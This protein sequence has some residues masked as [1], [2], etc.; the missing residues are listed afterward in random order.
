MPLPD[1]R[2]GDLL[3]PKDHLRQAHK[4]FATSEAAYHFNDKAGIFI[5]N[6]N[7]K[8]LVIDIETKTVLQ[9]QCQFMK[10]Q[11]MSDLT[12]VGWTQSWEDTP[13]IWDHNAFWTLIARSGDDL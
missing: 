9:A 1:I 4:L 8:L 13:E 3:V 12:K 11:N 7:D 10:L 5:P 6:A 2:L